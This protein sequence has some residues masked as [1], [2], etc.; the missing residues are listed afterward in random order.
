M[1]DPTKFIN[2]YIDV[3]TG[4]LHEQLGSVLQL[5]T[6]I[7]I[8][9]ETIQEKDNLIVS[10]SQE[11]ENIRTQLE[12]EKNTAIEATR[13]HLEA[14]K[15]AAIAAIQNEKATSSGQDAEIIHSLQTKLSHMDTLLK[16]LSDT[17]KEV[18]AKNGEIAERDNT[19]ASLEQK[20][21]EATT[22]K[23]TLAITK[24]SSAS[25]STSK[26]QLNNKVKT[27]KT[28]EPDDDF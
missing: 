20:L 13:S 26:V 19:I 25:A 21:I 9:T 22:P 27:T 1:S 18:Q 16:Q 15:N 10:L 23:P 8:M 5:K 7:K 24:S 14:E 4:T 17:Q 2:T 6:Q 11:K 12:N 3:I 28:K